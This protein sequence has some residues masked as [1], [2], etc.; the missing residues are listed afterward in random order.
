V[1]WRQH[2]KLYIGLTT[3]FLGAAGLFSYTPKDPG[4]GV[5]HFHIGPWVFDLTFGPFATAIAIPILLYGFKVIVERILSRRDA[6][7][8]EAKRIEDETQAKKE[9]ELE[10][11]KLEAIRLKAQLEKERQEKIENLILEN[12]NHFGQKLDKICKRIEDQDNEFEKH[13]HLINVD[14]KLYR[15]N[16]KVK[17]ELGGA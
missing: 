3:I 5:N 17:L 4:E 7:A 8:A 12:R 1:D 2:W 6:E 13:E 14:G 15:S 16:G 10:E 11:R 9:K